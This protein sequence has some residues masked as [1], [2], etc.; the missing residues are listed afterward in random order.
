MNKRLVSAMPTDITIIGAGGHGKV[1]TDALLEMGIDNISIADS[2]AALVGNYLLDKPICLLGEGL[3]APSFHVA[4]GL[5]VI[6]S[7]LYQNYKHYKY[8]TIVS[9]HAKVSQ[10]ASILDGVF[11][12]AGSVIGPSSVLGRGV[13]VNHGAIVDHDC[14][15]EE[16]SHI[17]PN[18]TLLGGV[19][20]GKRVLVGSGSV[21][22]PGVVIEDDVIIG[23]GSVVTKNVKKGMTLAG[24]PAREM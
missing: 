15:V 17:A 5:N 23:A 10:H 6:R 4:V 22:L 7:E 21:V 19:S 3:V 24:N 9:P 8:E 12:A 14:R 1:V 18:A 13:I 20:I 11:V 16:F 2:D